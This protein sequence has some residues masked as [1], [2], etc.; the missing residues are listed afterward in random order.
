[1]EKGIWQF[2]T[3][4][5][6]DNWPID[7]PRDYLLIVNQAISNKELERIKKCEEKSIPFG[8]DSWVDGIVKKHNIEQ[9]LRS[10]GG[11]KGG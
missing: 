5:D 6:P 4:E 8:G 1:M 2:K 11:K 10:T 3:K 7:V 9:V